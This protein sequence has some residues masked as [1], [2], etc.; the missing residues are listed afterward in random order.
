MLVFLKQGFSLKEKR[1]FM[2]KRILYISLAV[3]VFFVLILI[4][5]FLF[6][7]QR[8]KT[9]EGK[10]SISETTIEEP[11]PDTQEEI[12]ETTLPH[13]G[14]EEDRIREENRAPRIRTVFYGEDNI[15]DFLRTDAFPMPYEEAL[16]SF[17]I[18]SEDED[19]DVLGYNID[20]THGRIDDIEMLSDDSV[21]FTWHSP[22]NMEA[23]LTPLN[24][25][26]TVRVRDTTGDED[27]MEI[28]IALLPVEPEIRPA[29]TETFFLSESI[30]YTIRA[31][32][33]AVM[34][35]EYY[36]GDNG[37]DDFK[38]FISFDISSL[39]D[40]E[41][42]SARLEIANVGVRGNPTGFFSYIYVHVKD[43]GETVEERDFSG[44]TQ[45]FSVDISTLGTS[46]VNEGP[47]IQDRL[48]RSVNER[49]TYY[50]MSFG[51]GGRGIN[52]GDDVADGYT[53]SDI[54]L[55][56]TYR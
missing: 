31:A 23:S 44:G 41:I 17:T 54:R 34:A 45:L 15:T 49:K 1:N 37:P 39:A 25:Q 47:N 26:I 30:S 3:I 18:I 6:Y 22:A 43:Y 33:G 7:C 20:C 11:P 42:E 38:V 24:A 52:N 48:Q 55:I 16:H 4:L 35:G 56:V 46:I 29:I 53:L 5:Y 14:E 13:D 27:R 50:Q 10:I 40:V 12:P 2:K 32:D 19:G 9:D 36:I 21:L 28:R 8:L 51:L